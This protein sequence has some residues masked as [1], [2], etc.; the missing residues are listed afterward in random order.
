MVT[1]GLQFTFIKYIGID[2]MRH[3]S[4]VRQNKDGTYGHLVIYTL[5]NITYAQ[6]QRQADLHTMTVFL[7]RGLS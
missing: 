7:L 1:Y 5:A 6:A 3:H 4:P 2:I